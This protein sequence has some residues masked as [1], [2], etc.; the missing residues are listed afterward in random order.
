MKLK[1]SI[2]VCTASLFVAFPIL[3]QRQDGEH[4]HHGDRGNHGNNS[5]HSGNGSNH[6]GHDDD[7]NSAEHRQDAPHGFGDLVLATPSQ[8][9][10]SATE[11]TSV[12]SALRSRSLTTSSGASIPT[13][14]QAS[15]YALLTADR[16]Q[17]ASAAE[18]STALLRAGPN[19][20]AMVPSIVRG[21]SG[22]SS[23]P[24][25]LPSV[26]AQY[27]DF[28]KAASSTFISNPPPEFLALHAVLARLVTAASSAKY[29]SK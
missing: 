24:A 7:G 29:S 2:V 13:S 15:T 17:P 12:A 6:S 27:N 8:V 5:N 11:L 10:A 25:Q 14:A 28:T 18:I 19:A 26:V 16:A 22:L 20:G 1:I 9:A 23:Y 4:G 3:A 21:F